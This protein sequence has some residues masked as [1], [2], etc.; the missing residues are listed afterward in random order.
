ESEQSG[1]ECIPHPDDPMINLAWHSAVEVEKRKHVVSNDS[2]A[3]FPCSNQTVIKFAK[4]TERT[5]FESAGSKSEYYSLVK[6]KLDRA[7]KQLLEKAAKRL[8]E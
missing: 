8:R 3:I 6:D 4:N 2:K 1:N 7:P 5:I